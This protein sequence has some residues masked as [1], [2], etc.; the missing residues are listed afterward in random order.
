MQE[1]E[2]LLM[3]FGFR[4][5]R[6]SG[7]HHIYRY[8][9]VEQ[10]RKVVVPLHGRK[11]KPFYVQQVVQVLDELFPEEVTGDEEEDDGQND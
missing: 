2:T 9:D 10:I 8:N 5:E 11:V 3:R 4:L 7:S 6:V 1:V